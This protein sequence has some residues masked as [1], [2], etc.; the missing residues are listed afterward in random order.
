MRDEAYL[1]LWTWAAFGQL[2]LMLAFFVRTTSGGKPTDLFSG[3]S[4]N[5]T[6]VPALGLPVDL[7]LGLA[8]LALT[9]RWSLQHQAEPWPRRVPAYHFAQTDIDVA[10]T[11][12]KL[13]KVATFFVAHVLTLAASI[14]MAVR[15][16]EAAIYM[17]SGS[18]VVPGG[19]THF[20][21]TTVSTAAASGMLKFGN[22][23][24][25]EHFAVLPW[26][27]AA[28][29]LVYLG[30]WAVVTW[31]LFRPPRPVGSEPP[32]VLRPLDP[33]TKNRA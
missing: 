16:F 9:L 23:E 21:F 5:A 15:Y 26:V 30:L 22:P 4:V 11:L 28:L 1:K 18:Q 32:L 13:Y 6:T 12:G 27:Y 33:P 17:K 10:T 31:S 2:T 19:W 8:V 29:G 24:G 20:S 25:V 7:L 3:L 14:Q